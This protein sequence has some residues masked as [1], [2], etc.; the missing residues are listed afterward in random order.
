MSIRKIAVPKLT[1]K[2][3]LQLQEIESSFLQLLFFL[4][5][6]V[7]KKVKTAESYPRARPGPASAAADRRPARIEQLKFCLSNYVLGFK[8]YVQRSGYTYKLY[9]KH[10]SIWSLHQSNLVFFGLGKSISQNSTI[11]STPMTAI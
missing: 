3:F 5:K 9:N 6:K 7:A 1:L 2:M 10:L 8:E 4:T 11:E